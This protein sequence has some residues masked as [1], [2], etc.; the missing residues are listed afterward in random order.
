MEAAFFLSLFSAPSAS[1]S[2]R[3]PARVGRLILKPVPRPKDPPHDRYANCEEGQGHAK[4]DD[5]V[6][7]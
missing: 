4:A 3:L 5:Q 6:D 2:S 1:C 7:V